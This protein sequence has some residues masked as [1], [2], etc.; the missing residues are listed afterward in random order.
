MLKSFTQIKKHLRLIE[1]VVVLTLLHIINNKKPEFLQTIISYFQE[2]FSSV[3]PDV[4]M[5]FGYKIIS[6]II[7]MLLIVLLRNKKILKIFFPEHFFKEIAISLSI[8]IIMTMPVIIGLLTGLLE[9]SNISS[10]IMLGL[11]L[12]FII[13]AFAE[14]IVS[15]A[16][17]LTGS[18][19]D[20]P[21]TINQILTNKYLWVSALFFGLGHLNQFGLW[22]LT[23]ILSGFAFG[24]LYLC[25]GN[26]W[27]GFFAH[28]GMQIGNLLVKDMSSGL[29]FIVM[30]IT[31]SFCCILTYWLSFGFNPTTTSKGDKTNRS[32]VNIGSEK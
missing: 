31:L 5:S 24:F 8:G 9:Y 12:F 21:L 11:V 25:R 1:V 26:I 27:P 20:S 22:G 29:H 7:G 4:K 13:N 18:P 30:G 14:E 3:F 15:R 2:Y 19:N 6:I 28:T 32:T 17:P 16:Y 10:N 23:A